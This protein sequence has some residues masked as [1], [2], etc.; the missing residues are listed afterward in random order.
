MRL[1]IYFSI[2]CFLS[3]S[4]NAVKKVD[5]YFDT[6]K[7]FEQ[8]IKSLKAQHVFIV[9]DMLFNGKRETTKTD[10]INWEKELSAF[11]LVDLLKPSY[12]G[13]FSIDSTKTMENKLR[14]TYHSIESKSELRNIEI[15]LNNNSVPYSL[16][17]E[18]KNENAIYES[19]KK[20]IYFTD[21]AFIISGKQSIKLTE[22]ANY[23]VSAKIVK[24]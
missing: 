5:N 10:S 2:F 11:A 17:F 22:G 23:L 13:R 14:I 16:F 15:I 19:E 6:K 3:C 1:I 20:L 18:F 8:Q 12:Q 7:F 4:N 21:S 24:N 9:K